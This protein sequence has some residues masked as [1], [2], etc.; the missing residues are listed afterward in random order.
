MKQEVLIT[1]RG[2][3]QYEKDKPETVE[4]MTRGIMLDRNGKYSISY[5]ETE[6]TGTPGVVTTFFIPNSQ[7]VILSREGP[8]QSRMVFSEGVKDESLY[9]LGFGSLLVGICARKIDVDLSEQGGRLRIDYTVEI[10]QS[11]TS[12]NSYEILVKPIK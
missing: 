5:T 2:T 9:D 7:R 6:L 8:I 1:L 12:R 4:L 11:V 10:E 3:Q